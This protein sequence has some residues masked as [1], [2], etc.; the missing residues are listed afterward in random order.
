[1]T[2]APVRI[3][4]ILATLALVGIISIQMFWVSKAVSNENQQFQHSVQMALNNVV[5]SLCQ[6]E[7]TD[8]PLNNPVERI[9]NNYFIVRTNNKINLESV[10]YLLKAEL[11]KRAIVQDFEYGVYDCENEQ[12]IYGDF[13]SSLSN[14]PKIKKAKF[15]SLKDEAYYFGLYFP[16]RSK[17]SFGELDFWK[18]TTGLTILVVL[19]FAY[20][21]FVILRQKKLSS[22]QKDFVNNITHEL[23]T[24][25]ATLK[26]ASE[27]FQS[28]GK[29]APPRLRQYSQV[30][31]Q[32]TNKLEKHVNQLL[33]TSLLEN[34]SALNKEKLDLASIIQQVIAEFRLTN[35]GRSVNIKD[36]VENN[37]FVL[38]DEDLISDTIRNLL[39]NAA[40]YGEG[41]IAISAK[42]EGAF[43]SVNVQ[44]NGKGIPEHLRSKVF[45]KFYRVPSGDKHD[46]KGFGLGLYF[47]KNV[48]KKHKGKVGIFGNGNLFQLQFRAHA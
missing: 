8:I 29:D 18:V 15:P 4:I 5:E 31:A 28:D 7:G 35:I 3:L 24:P 23:K 43:V 32:E 2:N 9:S 36:E 30:M 44:D 1:M 45:K 11:E 13:V 16:Q 41:E 20:G 39:D 22:I 10:E 6:I 46:V 38:A 37:L 34:K 12:M 19:F 26:I 48:M 27:V 17:G 25:L 33:R 47:V 40:K 42:K 14:S 21:L